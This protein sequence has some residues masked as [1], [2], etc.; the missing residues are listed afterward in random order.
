MQKT[1]VRK[2]YEDE[3][4]PDRADEAIIQAGEILKLSLIHI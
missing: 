4:K 3:I 1:S 2:V